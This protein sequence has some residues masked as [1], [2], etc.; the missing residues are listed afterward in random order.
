MKTTRLLPGSWRNLRPGRMLAAALTMSFAL[1]AA[2]CG[3][4]GP[5]RPAAVAAAS[6]GYHGT[7]VDPPLAVAPVTFR[8]TDGNAVRLDRMTTEPESATAV[9][10]GFTH[11]NDVCPTTMADLAAAR[12]AL[13]PDLARR[14]QLVFVTVDPKRDTVP[15]LRT[16][17]HRFDPSIAGLRGPVRLVHR[18]EDSLFASQSSRSVMAPSGSSAG[19]TKDP[20]EEHVHEGT[21]ADLGDYEVDHT[22]IVYPFGPD[23]E[24]LIYTGGATATAYTADFERLLR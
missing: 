23:G 24:S 7:V 14:L 17:L 6:D 1:L 13:A 8:D 2:G 22:S 4:G 16:W 15:V 12:R 20:S 5:E 9:F 11:C 19:A 3:S 10:F 18:A 21:D